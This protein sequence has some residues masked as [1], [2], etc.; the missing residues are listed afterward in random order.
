MQKRR[1]KIVYLIN[2]LG[3]GGAE[4]MLYRLLKELDRDR[5]NPAVIALLNFSGPLEEKIKKLGIEVYLTSPRKK[6]YLP[7]LL[8]LYRLLKQLGPDILHTQLFAADILGRTFGRMLKVPVVISSIRNEYYGGRGRNL[9]IRWTERFAHKTTFVCRAA[10]ERFVAEGVVPGN[11]AMVIYNGLDLSAYCHGLDRA[12]KLKK[13][14]EL[15][16]PGQKML[17]VQGTI[18]V[19]K[20]IPEQVTLPDQ[21]SLPDQG[22]LLLAVGSLSR[23]KAYPDLLQALGMIKEKEKESKKDKAIDDWQLIVAG[24]GPL[25][26]ELQALSAELGLEQRVSFLGR[27]DDVPQL[28]AAADALVLSSRWEG[29]PGVVLEA[30]AAELPV[31]AT[32]A[33]GTP[34]LVVAGETGF[35][36]PA[37]APRGLAG[38]LEKLFSLPAEDLQQLGRAGR[39]RV[40]DHF[41]VAR[42]AG[43]YQDLY[44]QELPALRE[45]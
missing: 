27:R 43:A 13:R 14:A 42:M 3:S 10:A 17:P 23:Q 39:R 7:A 31:V 30:M 38:A 34:E 22:F 2:G 25:K 6:F 40:E 32:N 8:R 18:P 19:H 21:E 12:A 24:R 29:L 44:R 16:L 41:T 33:G 9:L 11:K 5:F 20:P 37:A 45:D 1:V 4:M 36:V 35:L 28:M 26:K 15:G